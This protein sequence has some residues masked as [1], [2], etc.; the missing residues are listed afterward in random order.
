MH[1]YTI[2]RL[3]L[4]QTNK[5]CKG[6]GVSMSIARMCRKFSR[7]TKCVIEHLRGRLLAGLFVWLA[8]FVAYLIAKFAFETADSVFKPM[9]NFIPKI[10]Q[11]APGIGTA[12]LVVFLYLT[13]LISTYAFGKPIVKF[14]KQ[15]P[16]RIPGFGMIY[17]WVH[18]AVES[19]KPSTEGAPGGIGKVVCMEFKNLEGL[20]AIGLLMNIIDVENKDVDDIIVSSKPHGIIYC[21]SSPNPTTGQ[22]IIVPM[23]AIRDVNV[24]LDKN[25]EPQKIY[26]TQEEFRK[27]MTTAMSKELLASAIISLGSLFPHKIRL[28]R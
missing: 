1:N 22:I 28:T 26:M 27:A 25:Q 7:I 14:I 3:V 10:S 18:P 17:G 11:D 8:I 16:Y 12:M 13:G 23:D 5:I 9:P 2:M 6:I 19:F 4:R 20:K 15:F 21:A 24:I